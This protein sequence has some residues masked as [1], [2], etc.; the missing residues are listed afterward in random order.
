M[1]W[2]RP[3]RNRSS[4][5]RRREA[6]PPDFVRDYRPA[7]DA[8]KHFAPPSKEYLPPTNDYRD[9]GKHYK[10][11]SKEYLPPPVIEKSVPYD[12]PSKAYLPPPMDHY[13]KKLPDHYAPPSKDYL[14]PPLL[15]EPDYLPDYK[16]KGDHYVPPA[17]STCPL[18]QA[19]RKTSPP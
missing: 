9:D 15:K 3:C 18:L 6:P 17:R 8:A 11:P 7:Q 1:Y 19:T 10:P 16:P 14:P 2:P 4:S 13:D 5:L 12:L